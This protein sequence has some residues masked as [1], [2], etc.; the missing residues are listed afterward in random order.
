MSK[1]IDHSGSTFDSFLEEENLLQETE[2]VALKRVIAWQLQRAMQKKRIT[3]TVLARRLHTSRSQL[4][5]LLDPSEA[6][7][8]LETITKAAGALGKRIRISIVD[9]QGQDLKSAPRKPARKVSRRPKA[10][11]VPA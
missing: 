4:N 1:L 3:K 11:V 9:G 8:S 5:R 2:A 6:G 7:V 10:K